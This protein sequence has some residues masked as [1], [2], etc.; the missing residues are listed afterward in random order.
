MTPERPPVTGYSVIL[1][2]DW[3]RIPLRHGT[4]DAVRQILDEAF[5]RIPPGAPRDKVGAY[6]RELERRLRATVTRAQHS[7]A[8][9]LYIPF[10]SRRNVNLGASLVVSETL[11]PRRRGSDAGAPTDVA[12]GLL[13]QEAAEGADLTSGDLDGALAV[14]REHVVRADPGRGAELASRRVEYVASVPDDPHRWFVAAFSAVGSGRP[15]DELA[16]A[17]VDWFDAVMTTFRWR[18]G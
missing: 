16:D 13:S 7:N 9:D 8:L 3:A 4:Q 6:E 15:D 12:V 2:D 17:L 10:R 11:L 14:R 18:R 1:P 5:S